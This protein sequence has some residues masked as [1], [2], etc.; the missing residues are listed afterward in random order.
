MFDE[1]L[2]NFIG[3]DN[4]GTDNMTAILVYFHDNIKAQK[5][6]LSP[7]ISVGTDNGE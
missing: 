3:G 1:C 6:D 5:F 4:K 2:A 7:A